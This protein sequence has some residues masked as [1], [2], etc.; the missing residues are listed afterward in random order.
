MSTDRG[1]D[2]PEVTL[3]AHFADL[4]R[5]IAAATPDFAIKVTKA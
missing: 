5:E 2:A 4:K 3:P 1:L